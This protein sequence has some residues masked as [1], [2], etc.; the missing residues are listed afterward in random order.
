MRKKAYLPFV[1]A[2]I[3]L[4][5]GE[6][7]QMRMHAKIEINLKICVRACAYTLVCGR[8]S[9]EV[10]RSFKNGIEQIGHEWMA[11]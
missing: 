7:L 10:T 1:V 8:I 11:S 3:I 6:Q 2:L 4:V 5:F 9:I